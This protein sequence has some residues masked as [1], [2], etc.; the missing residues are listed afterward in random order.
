MVFECKSL[1]TKS[2]AVRLLWGQTG[3]VTFPE[4]ILNGKLLFQCSEGGGG[5]WSKRE[6]P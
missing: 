6:V 2:H 4:G 5:A 3:L 1:T